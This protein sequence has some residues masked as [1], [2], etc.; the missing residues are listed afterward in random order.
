M[1]KRK[2]KAP[3]KKYVKKP[4]KKIPTSRVKNA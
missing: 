2:E 3:V 1:M 4:I